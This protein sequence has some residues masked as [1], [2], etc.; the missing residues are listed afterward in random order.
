MNI[1]A[2]VPAAIAQ[3]AVAALLLVGCASSG[4]RTRHAST[5]ATGRND[6]AGEFCSGR[7]QA[8][9]TGEGLI[10]VTGRLRPTR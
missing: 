3:I 9:Y 4:H 5:M 10:C 8:R 1:H 6:H 7:T 2:G